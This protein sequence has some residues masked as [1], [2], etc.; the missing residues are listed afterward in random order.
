MQSWNLLCKLDCPQ[1]RSTYLCLLS[2]GVKVTLTMPGKI[3]FYFIC[4]SVFFT[5]MPSAKGS[6]KG[7]PNILKLKLLTI[8]SYHVGARRSST[9][10]TSD[11]NVCLSPINNYYTLTN[12]KELFQ[13]CCRCTCIQVRRQLGGISS[14]LPTYGYMGPRDSIRLS[15]LAA[16]AF[17]AE[18]SLGVWSMNVCVHTCTVFKRRLE[19]S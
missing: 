2:A 19:Y 11:L 18:P 14:L 10:A 1:Q 17:T 4:V 5:C 6:Q 12:W 7:A 16:S 13:G 9:K 8:V 15:G 3:Y